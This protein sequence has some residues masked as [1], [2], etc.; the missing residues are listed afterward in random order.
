MSGLFCINSPLGK[1]CVERVGLSV[2]LEKGLDAG[3]LLYIFIGEV[4]LSGVTATLSSNTEEFC[5]SVLL[6]V[7]FAPSIS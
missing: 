5:I 2:V 4:R 7:L 3:I 6:L 1:G